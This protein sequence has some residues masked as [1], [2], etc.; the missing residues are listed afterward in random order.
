MGF[1]IWDEVGELGFDFQ[2][3]Y[4]EMYFGKIM[5]KVRCFKNT[6]DNRAFLTCEVTPIVS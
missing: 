6:N 1:K 2:N 5:L 4:G 3:S